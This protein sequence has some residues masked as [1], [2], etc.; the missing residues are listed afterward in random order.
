MISTPTITHFK[1]CKFSLDN[2][3]NVLVEKPI[4][5][6]LKEVKT[7]NR[8]SIK[9]KK[10]I[11]V[12]YP[13]IFSGSINFIKKVIDQNIYGK[14]LEIKFNSNKSKIISIGHRNPQGFF[15]S[16]KYNFIISTEHGPRGGDEINKILSNK[17]Y[18]WPIVSLGEKYDFK[19]GFI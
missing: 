18:G 13:F 2:S 8:I 5:L 9:K 1:I 7:L 6:S 15:Y 12:D 14:I 19:Y 11:F 16:E 17:N 3:K 4:S 10:M